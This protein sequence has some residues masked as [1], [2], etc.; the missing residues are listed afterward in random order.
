[1]EQGAFRVK[2]AVMRQTP[3]ELRMVVVNAAKWPKDFLEHKVYSCPA[4]DPSYKHYPAKYIGDYIS[5][6]VPYVGVVQACVRLSADGRHR[7]MWQ[8]DE[9]DEG[10][11]IRE[12][13]V[14]ERETRHGKYP[15]LV[16]LHSQVTK[17]EF[18]Y[19]SP[20][21]P[22][23]STYYFDL[24]ELAPGNVKELADGLQETWWSAMP[25]WRA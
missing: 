15:R 5:K 23:G 2:R 13:I 4:E 18:R 8:F 16:F 17:T 24:S 25:K 10:E 21:G 14:R 20:G 7:I 22:Q 3:P 19:D 12:A 9:I 6:G 1:M 11:A